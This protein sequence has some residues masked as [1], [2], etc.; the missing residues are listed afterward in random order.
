MSYATGTTTTKYA[1]KTIADGDLAG[2]DGINEVIA[3]I[4]SNIPIAAGMVMLYNGATAPTGWTNINS[5]IVALQATASF[6]GYIWI[7]KS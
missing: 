6:T 2:N 3:S 4:D 7:K 1:F 5:T